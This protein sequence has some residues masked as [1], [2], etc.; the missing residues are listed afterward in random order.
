MKMVKGG[1][2]YT[3]HA[4]ITCKGGAIIYDTAMI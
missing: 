1:A 3:A 2:L 4:L